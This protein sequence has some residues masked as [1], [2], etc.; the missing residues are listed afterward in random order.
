MKQGWCAK[1]GR[2]IFN[3]I[4]SHVLLNGGGID[5]QPNQKEVEIPFLLPRHKRPF[6][7]KIS[8]VNVQNLEFLKHLFSVLNFR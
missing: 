3:V 8:Y 5:N 4:F 1:T 7:P 6:E 2:M